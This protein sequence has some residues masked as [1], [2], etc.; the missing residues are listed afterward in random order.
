G[1]GGVGDGSQSA[2]ITVFDFTLDVP[3]A[4]RLGGPSGTQFVARPDTQPL[5]V[6]ANITPPGILPGVVTWT[7]AQEIPGVQPPTATVRRTSGG[8]L[9]VSAEIGTITKTITIFIL[10]FRLEVTG[11][12]RITSGGSDFIAIVDA[13]AN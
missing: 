6:V 12:T 7:G 10:D 3:G 13:T 8:T 5:T 4:T 1:A 9:T 2:T 11:A